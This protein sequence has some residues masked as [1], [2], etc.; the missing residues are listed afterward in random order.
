MIFYCGK[1]ALYPNPTKNT[2][3]I[4]GNEVIQ[5]IEIFDFVGK[6]VFYQQNPNTEITIDFLTKGVYVS[7]LKFE[8]GTSLFKLIKE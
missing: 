2:F 6:S 4:L 5:E 1:L 8:K 3:S 7:I